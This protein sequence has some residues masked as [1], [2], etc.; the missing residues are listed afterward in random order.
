MIRASRLTLLAAVG[1]SLAA[2]SALPKLSLPSLPSLAGA[3]S[4]SAPAVPAGPTRASLKPGQ[5]AHEV[6]DIAPDPRVRFGVLPSGMRYALMKNATPPQ[7]AA[8]RLWFDTGSLMEADDQQGLAHF[9]EHMAFNGSK[10]VPE[11]EMI[12]ILERHGLAFGADTNASTGLDQTIYQLDLPK[13]DSATVDSSL[14]LLRETAGELTIAPEAVDRERGVVLSEERTR[15]SPGY[16]VAIKSMDFQME[17]Q[18]PPKRIPIG[19]TEVL[20]TAPAQRIRDYYEAYYRP[21]RAVLVAVGDFDLDAMEAKIKARFGDWTAKGPAG[22]RPDLG[23]VAKRGQTVRLIVEPG[24][25]LAVQLSWASTPD[26]LIETK[27]V[28]VR[29]TLRNLGFAV[30]NRRMQ[31]LSR[32]ADPPFIAGGA[33]ASD[34][35]GAVRMTTLGATAQPGRWREALAALEQEQRRV[36][37]FGVRQDELDREI[38]SLRAS[39][40]AAASGEATQR[41]TALAAGIVGSLT[42]GETVTSPSQ[43]LT[44]F[45]EI[46]KGL[47]ADQVSAVLKAAFTGQGPLILI[48]TP[49]AIEGGEATVLAAYADS[50]KVAVQAPAGPGVTAWPYASFGSIGK[51]VEQKDISDLDAVF[52]RFENGVRLT[53]KPTKFRDDQV[54]IKARIANG[55]LD[56]PTTSQ[57]PLWSGSAFIEGGLKQISAQDMERV[58]NGKIWNA[59]L[60]IED[61]AFTLSG[62]TRPEDVATE[63]QVLA[64]FA[65]EP[66]WRPEAFTRVKTYYG[67]IH[68]QLETTTGGV[69]GRELS[70]LLHKGDKRWTFP[71]RADIASA[72]L[73]TLKAAVAGPLSSGQIEVVVV[74]DIT[75]EKA[76]AA[77]A[78]TFGALPAR[79]GLTAPATAREVPFPDTSTTPVVLTHKGRADQAQLFMAWRTDDLFSDLQRS[80]DTSVLAQVMQLRLTDELR[81]KQGATYSPSAGATH[82]VVFNDWGYL[83]VSVEVPPEKLDGVMA[84]IRQIAADL[85]DKPVTEDELDRA[86]K[87]RIDQ[88]EKSRVT[89]EYWLGNLSGAQADP[90]ILDATRSVI[91][92]LER[93]KAADVQRAARTFLGA[94]RSWTVLVKPEGK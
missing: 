68:D 75:V 19:K 58:L 7:Q 49:S 4:N 2:C 88:I 60:G 67:T 37:Q 78:E 85:R 3:G 5:W 90:R 89:N 30:L 8:L 48:P 21:E 22:K 10:N 56:L 91:A 23:K 38:A 18:L 71:T 1:L 47:T 81:E 76:I 29:D 77:V 64:A 93:V 42:D 73:D 35:Y 70:G 55:L 11:G 92:G 41:S 74:G 59:G 54:L 36:L 20:K 45:D 57:S 52:V 51:V 82:S 28:D 83:S 50:G 14:M 87:P 62:R 15:D 25:P 46:V 12:K 65:Q 79:S 26:G 40:V 43:N 17:G 39:L 33:F 32:A 34:Q 9:L 61:D 53:V 63:L 80:R 44:A 94:D 6:S 24:A 16:R 66:G 72:S 31:A 13:T 69:I 27:A 84:S 86:K